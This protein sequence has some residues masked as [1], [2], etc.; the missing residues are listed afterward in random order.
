MNK[1]KLTPKA[2][3][4]FSYTDLEH[5]LWHIEDIGEGITM[6][7]E[8]DEKGD[9]VLR[10]CQASLIVVPGDFVAIDPH[11]FIYKYKTRRQ[12]ITQTI[13]LIITA[14]AIVA[15]IIWT[16]FMERKP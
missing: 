12:M 15:A 16:E 9:I 4:R 10:T 3:A 7:V 2:I 5:K 14:A 11:G 8:S 1:V 13:F 6:R